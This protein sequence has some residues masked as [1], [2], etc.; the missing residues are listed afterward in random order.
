MD[1][2]KINDIEVQDFVDLTAETIIVIEIEE[3]KKILKNAGYF[4][5]N[6]WHTCNV[7]IDYSCTQEDAQKI[8]YLAL[9]N[10]SIVEQVWDEIICEADKLNLKEK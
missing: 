10:E 7:T 5:D 3:A 9:T 4:V 1:A 8:L 2:E 6:L